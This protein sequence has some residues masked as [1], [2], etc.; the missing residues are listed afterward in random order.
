[1]DPY[2]ELSPAFTPH[3]WMYTQRLLLH[4]SQFPQSKLLEHSRRDELEQ[5][6]SRR[7][8]PLRHSSHEPQ[9]KSLKHSRVVELEL[10]FEIFTH[11]LFE[12]LLHDPHCE[13]V[14]QYVGVDELELE[15][16]VFWHEIEQRGFDVLYEH[17]MRFSLA[18]SAFVLHNCADPN[19]PQRFAP[20]PPP[21]ALHT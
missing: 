5:L 4:C 1:M 21:T 11:W 18:Q 6:L 14:V 20:P 19:P 7:Q 3:P 16:L 13:S 9:S 15:A 12:H 17:V 10:Q 2:P 8:M